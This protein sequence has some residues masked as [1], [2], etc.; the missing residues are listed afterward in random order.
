MKKKNIKKFMAVLGAVLCI[1]TVVILPASAVGLNDQDSYVSEKFPDKVTDIYNGMEIYPNIQWSN[2]SY[3][4]RAY[5]GSDSGQF[6]G[7]T[8]PDTVVYERYITVLEGVWFDYE[9]DGEK[10][11]LNIRYNVKYKN[12]PDSFHFDQS[13]PED[14][15]YKGLEGYSLIVH[16]YNVR[17]KIGDN[18]LTY[19]ER[20]EGYNTF[21]GFRFENVDDCSIS[22]RILVEGYTSQNDDDDIPLP[23]PSYDSGI[24]SMGLKDIDSYID[25]YYNKG[26][27]EGI[28]GFEEAKRKAYADGYSAGKN[29]AGDDE[30]NLY[31]LITTVV[32]S[33]VRFINEALNFNVF[34]VNIAGFVTMLMTLALVAFV[35]VVIVK[36]LV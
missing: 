8:N 32:V 2:D 36:F 31:N 34:G 12:Q 35:I 7:M 20:S 27:T 18:G 24:W 26:Y 17:D 23:M 33:P 10:N 1:I 30:F 28:K 29:F 11:D 22:Y 21:Y 14:T 4:F 13:A 9:G 5:L 16:L 19:F 25:F 6:Y 3:G 15:W